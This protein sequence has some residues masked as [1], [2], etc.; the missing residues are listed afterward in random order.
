MTR[1]GKHL[2]NPVYSILYEI[3]NWTNES[4]SVVDHKPEEDYWLQCVECIDFNIELLYDDP[5]LQYFLTLLDIFLKYF[6]ESLKVNAAR[7]AQKYN[8]FFF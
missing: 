2:P 6:F 4:V 5:L 1:G 8:C 3:I 7:K